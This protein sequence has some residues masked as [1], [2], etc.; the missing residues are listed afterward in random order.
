MIQSRVIQYMN[1]QDN[2]NNLEGKRQP[3][4]LS[5]EDLNSYFKGKHS[6]SRRKGRIS[7]QRN[8]AIKE[9]NGNF[10][11]EKHNTKVKIINS[12]G[13]VEWR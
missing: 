6:C 3:Q 4:G 7:R 13:S 12:G 9:L 11:I 1:M 2:L 8:K 10:V 5:N